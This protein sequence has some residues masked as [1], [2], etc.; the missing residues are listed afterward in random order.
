MLKF[1][2]IAGAAV[3]LAGTP[4]QAQLLGGVTG[5]VNGAVGGNARRVPSTARF[6]EPELGR[7][8]RRDRSAD[9]ARSPTV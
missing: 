1:I 8:G 6:A 2:L 5:A 9:R 3:A 4:A 7:R